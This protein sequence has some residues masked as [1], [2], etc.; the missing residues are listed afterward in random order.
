MR[1]SGSA[2]DIVIDKTLSI[3]QNGRTREVTI[4][5]AL[6]HKTYQ[7]AVAGNRPAG[8]AVMKMIARRE[9]SL[10]AAKPPPRASYT[11]VMEREDPDNADDAMLVLGIACLDPAWTEPKKERRLLLE[12]WAVQAALGRRRSAPLDEKEV[13]EV[14]RS[15][16]NADSLRWPRGSGA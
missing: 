9:A 13:S 5:E 4:E 3:V 15:T 12:P 8:R 1:G 6:Q 16:H 11:F 2:F 14:R 10:A 7:Q